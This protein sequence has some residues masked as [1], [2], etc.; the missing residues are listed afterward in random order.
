MKVLVQIATVKKYLTN[1]FS[2]YRNKILLLIKILI[3][4]G[5]LAYIVSSIKITELLRAFESA[6]YY[7]ILLAFVLLIPN[8]FLQYWKWKITCKSI[9]N[10]EEKNIILYSLFQGLAAGAFTPFRVGEY[11]GRAFLFKEKTL[12]QVTIA[13]L[14]DKF[15]PLVILAFIGSISSVIFIY[16]FYNISIYL[17]A[18]LF[19]IIFVLFYLLIQ[20]LID[21]DFW[22]NFLFNKIKKSKTLQKYLGKIRFIKNLEKN[23]SLKMFS[24]SFLF[25]LCFVIQFVILV[26]AFTNDINLLDYFWSAT[27]VM[28]TKTFFPAI[29]LSELGIREGVSVFFL[30]EMGVAA[31]SAFNAS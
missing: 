1:S 22:N 9:L 3:A 24:I 2:V 28:F 27:L 21:P 31:A 18:S 6:N 30:G 4:G 15:F 11:F 17:A 16:L 26:S 29:S 5:L 10:V 25:Y 13:T 20:L 23:Y 8:I 12:L 14:I 19:A 7:L